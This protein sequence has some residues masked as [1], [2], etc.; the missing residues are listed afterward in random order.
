[1]QYTQRKEAYESGVLLSCEV[2]R[3]VKFKEQIRNIVNISR[4]RGYG[5]TGSG[6]NHLITFATQMT[7]RFRTGFRGL[8]Q[9]K[10]A[11]FH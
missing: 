2:K 4:N 1:M 10:P 5:V 6:I 9:V 3:V 7:A 8:D 11:V